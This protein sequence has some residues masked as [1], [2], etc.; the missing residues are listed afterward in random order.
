MRL[1]MLIE[2]NGANNL[3]LDRCLTCLLPSL[4]RTPPPLLHLPTQSHK[5]TIVLCCGEL[6]ATL[7]KWLAINSSCSRSC[8]HVLQFFKPAMCCPRHCYPLALTYPVKRSKCFA[9]RRHSGNFINCPCLSST[10]YILLPFPLLTLDNLNL[11]RDSPAFLQLSH[12]V[13]DL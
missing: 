13:K 6:R 12:E 10:L 5:C 8:C 7:A 4:S 9:A 11:L 1:Q 3:P 2:A